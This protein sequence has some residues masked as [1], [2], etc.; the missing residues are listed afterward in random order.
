MQ[1]RYSDRDPVS[2]VACYRRSGANPNELELENTTT[3]SRLAIRFESP[4][5][6]LQLA[7]TLAAEVRPI[8]LWRECQ[9][10][11]ALLSLVECLSCAVD[12]IRKA[13]EQ[14]RSQEYAASPHH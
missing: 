14:C 9:D 8:T 7:V 10:E 1:L 5:D 6:L 12:T 2:V 4:Q 13:H 3:G 11:E